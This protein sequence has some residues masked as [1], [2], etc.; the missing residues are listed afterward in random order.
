MR[1][2]LL[3]LGMSLLV[4]CAF[5]QPEDVVPAGSVITVRTDE[6]I[7]A[8]R[9]DGRVY[10]G[11]VTEDVV[12]RDGR[13]AVPRGSHVELLVRQASNHE[14]VLDL[15]SV[16]V[17]GRRYGIRADADEVRGSNNNGGRTAK[18]GVG[19]AILGTIVG[20]IAGGGKGA[21]IGAAAGGGAGVGIALATRGRQVNIPAEYLLSFR[22]ER[23]L[24]VTAPDNGY[25]RNGHHYHR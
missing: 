25:E 5:A 17:N 9:N 10:G 20:A 12:D 4:I 7:T 19:G 14:M 8:N 15:E 16:D 22:L 18:A 11:F 21:A 13:V 23:P 1:K 2:L 3:L 6:H 24:F